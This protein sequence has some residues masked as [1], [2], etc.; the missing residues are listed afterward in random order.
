[1]ASGDDAGY[2]RYVHMNLPHARTLVQRIGRTLEAL[3]AFGEEGNGQGAPLGD[4]LSA[5]EAE[6]R[7]YDEDPPM[8]QALAAGDRAAVVARNLVD[9]LL[10]RNVRS[11]RLGQHVRNLFECLGLQDEGARLSLLCGE[12]P[13]SPL[14]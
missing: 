7:P 3:D 10:G 6:L 12:R 4:A 14:R 8:E 1:M 11:D 9:A 5:L 2:R 13:D